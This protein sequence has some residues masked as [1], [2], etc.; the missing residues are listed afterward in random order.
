MAAGFVWVD[1]S[2]PDPSN[3][4]VELITCGVR[5]YVIFDERLDPQTP[6][7]PTPMEQAA[8]DLQTTL[9]PSSAGDVSADP[10][11]FAVGPIQFDH[12]NGYIE[13]EVTGTRWNDAALS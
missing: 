12:D 4:L 2:E 5:M 13:A 11:F 10:W 3:V 8:G 7:D 6:S 9:A 1:R